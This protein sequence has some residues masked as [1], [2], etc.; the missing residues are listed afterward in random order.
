MTRELLGRT[1]GK[2]TRL[3]KSVGALMN[4]PGEQ[5]TLPYHSACSTSCIW[6]CQ[7]ISITKSA[8]LKERCFLLALSIINILT[9]IKLTLLKMFCLHLTC[10]ATYNSS[11]CTNIIQCSITSFPSPTSQGS[12][13]RHYYKLIIHHY[14]CSR[15]IFLITNCLYN[16]LTITEMF[17]QRCLIS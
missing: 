4:L 16:V 9:I 14:V 17:W 8:L 13:C 2:C 10:F 5:A 15:S 11:L 12:L 6:N 1:Y 3:Q 7:L